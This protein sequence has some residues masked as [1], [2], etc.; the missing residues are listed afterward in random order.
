[1]TPSVR[2]IKLAIVGMTK[3]NGGLNIPE[4][5]EL[6]ASYDLPN[7]GSREELQM[8][9]IDLLDILENPKKETEEPK[10][11]PKDKPEKQ[12]EEPKE[13]P[14]E[15]PNEPMFVVIPGRNK[16]SSYKT[17]KYPLPDIPFKIAV[18]GKSQISGKTEL[19]RNLLDRPMNEN[20][21][22]GQGYRHDFKGSD[23]Y[24]ISPSYGID[25]IL[26]DIADSKNIP[27]GNIMIFYDEEVITRLYNKIEQDCIKAKREGDKPPNVLIYFD[28]VA[29]SGVFKKKIYGIINKIASNGRHINLS[30]IVTAQKYSSLSTSLRENLSCA[31]F[32]G[33]SE[34]QLELIMDDHCSIPKKDFKAIFRNFTSL[35]PH[36]FLVFNYSAPLDKFFMD[37]RF[38]PIPYNYRDIVLPPGI[39]SY[40][41]PKVSDY[42]IETKQQEPRKVD[43]DRPITL[44]H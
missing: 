10:D 17:K 1:M 41:R 35:E 37:E 11:K 31:I 26:G 2:T 22:H 5:R 28:D 12:R 19:I 42:D 18:V 44:V 38:K 27:E 14:K 21:I 16:F 8:Q 34:G 29:F 40:I 23:I 33:C 25:D 13:P 20:D 6:L 9:L 43:M 39:T 3:V 30:M 15:D 4:I 7:G 32:F 36:S 24:I